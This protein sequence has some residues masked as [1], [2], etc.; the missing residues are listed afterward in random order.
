MSRRAPHR[1]RLYIAGNALNSTLAGDN[2]VAFCREYLPGAHEIEVIDIFRDPKR[3][4]QDGIFLT[5]TLLT[6]A[7]LPLRR[8]VGTL[9]DTEVLCAALGVA[10]VA[11]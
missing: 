11:A 5:P 9:S 4:L 2:L 3:A 8:I 7:P 1:F 6:V 10:R